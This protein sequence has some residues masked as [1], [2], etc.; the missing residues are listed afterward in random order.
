MA[1]G[2]SGLMDEGKGVMREKQQSPLYRK[3][4]IVTH[5]VIFLY[6]TAFWIQIGAMPVSGCH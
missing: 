4:S 1:K 2:N 3:M 6:A 5:T